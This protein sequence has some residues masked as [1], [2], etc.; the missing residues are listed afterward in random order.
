MGGY[1]KWL[2]LQDQELSRLK[3]IFSDPPEVIGG[4]MEKE[5]KVVMDLTPLWMFGSDAKARLK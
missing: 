4:F 2:I 1:S 3:P 5:A